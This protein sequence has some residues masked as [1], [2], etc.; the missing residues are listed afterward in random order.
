MS[1]EIRLRCPECGALV[2]DAGEMRAFIRA[3]LAAYARMP[4]KRI[5]ARG[6]G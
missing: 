6:Q 5:G 1:E 4:M 2:I 3:V